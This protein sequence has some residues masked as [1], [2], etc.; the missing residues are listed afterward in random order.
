MLAGQLDYVA[1]TI[2][3]SEFA[4]TAQQREV[5]GVLAKETRDVHAALRALINNDLSNYNSLLR[6]RGLRPIEVQVPP[7]VF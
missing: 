1:S 4:P 2:A 3:A 6:G 5:A 7:I